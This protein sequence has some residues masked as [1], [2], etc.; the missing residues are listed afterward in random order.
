MSAIAE[1]VWTGPLE[2][3]DDYHW[4]IP[5]SYQR[6]M[7]V[8]GLVFTDDLEMKAITD[9]ESA[10]EITVGIRGSALFQDSTQS[11]LK[12]LYISRPFPDLDVRQQTKQGSTPICPSPCRREIK[13]PVPLKR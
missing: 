1:R 10:V 7:Q 2:K 6:G 12:T 8:P 11:V 4:R 5:M 13:P 3:V 9:F